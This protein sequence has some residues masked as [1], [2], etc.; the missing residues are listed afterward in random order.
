MVWPLWLLLSFP[1]RPAR[2]LSGC[3]RTEKFSGKRSPRDM[4]SFLM[5]DLRP[6]RPN[7]D[8]MALEYAVVSAENLGSAK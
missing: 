2:N 1:Q 5:S 7:L 4:F 8:L 6:M 3:C